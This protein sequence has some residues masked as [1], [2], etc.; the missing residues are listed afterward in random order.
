MFKIC[1]KRLFKKL[2]KLQKLKRPSENDDEVVFVPEM[3]SDYAIENLTLFLQET[4]G[5]RP[6]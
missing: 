6:I 4:E 1:L 5:D 3:L 2:C